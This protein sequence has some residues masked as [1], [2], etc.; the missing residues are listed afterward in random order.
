MTPRVLVAVPV[1]NHAPTL[2][3]VVLGLLERHPHVLVVD[4]GSDDLEPE[5]LAGL[6]VRMVRHGRNRGKGAA[7]R[8]AALEARRQ[9][10]SHIVTIDA[11]GQHDPA[12]LPLF[13]EAVAA[14]PLAVIVGA[15]DFNTENVPGSSRFG[16]AFSNFWL[17][18]Q[19]GVILSDV[20]SGYRAYPLIVLENLRCTE[21][22][23]SFEVEVLVRA[24]W[25]GFRLR[26]VNIRVHYPPKGER[27]SHFRAFM[28]N[29]HI[30]L[31]N[32]RLT[33][34]AIMP[35]PHRKFGEDEAGRVSPIHPLKS[36]R[37]L[38]RDD[39]TPAGLGLSAALGIF[40][41]TLPLIGIHSIAIL[42]AAGWL[43]WNKIAALAAS[44][45]CMP[46]LVPA[47]CIEAGHYLR[48]G[49]FLTE[50]SLRTLGYEAP[51]RLWEWILGSMLLAPL[52][53]ALTGAAV[54]VLARIVAA[55]LK[56]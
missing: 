48:H 31:L 56:P 14:D 6:P 10:M 11:D 35:V 12:D 15:R 49:V 37:I 13:L 52:L 29:A 22:R 41:G 20:Q 25:A 27:V 23:Y 18:V 54:W 46:P 44:Q 4:D 30:S 8:T 51:Q 36:L 2:R 21:N 5:V 34:R 45:L 33:I 1:Y 24:A 17:R 40:L 42:L 26:E 19:T 38:L 47:L 7:I 9:G 32:T 16:R 39:A 50:I 55:G 43:R 3:A 53:A 28:D